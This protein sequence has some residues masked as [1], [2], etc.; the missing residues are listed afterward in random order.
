MFDRY[1]FIEILKSIEGVNLFNPYTDT[2]DQCDGE[3]A[4][5]IRENNLLEYLKVVDSTNSIIVGEAPG[6]LGCRRTGLPFTDN[7]HLSIVQRI[8]GLG[9]MKQ[10]TITGKNRENSALFMWRT[11]GRLKKPPFVWNLIPLHPY[12]RDK[13]LS[14][15]TPIKKDYHV[16]NIAIE[17]LLENGGFD[18]IIAVGRIAEKYLGEM[19]YECTY[20]RHPS[21]GGSGIF[22]EAILREFD[23]K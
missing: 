2:C 18:K 15:R 11:I 4:A 6:Y 5:K 7:D 16:S 13:Q 17:Y 12:K 8:F 22:K 21:H 20:V 23:T 9:E 14:N 1:K 10:A 19:G 3:D